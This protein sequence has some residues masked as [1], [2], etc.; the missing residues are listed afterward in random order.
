MITHR[1]G[2][3]HI[4]I[5]HKI[6]LTDS[7]HRLRDDLADLPRRIACAVDLT[8]NEF[9]QLHNLLSRIRGTQGKGTP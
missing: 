9:L 5:A 8:E 3:R 2:R 6:H 7:G 4:P 1:C